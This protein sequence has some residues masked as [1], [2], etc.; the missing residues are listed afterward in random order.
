[1]RGAH[2]KIVDELTTWPDINTGPGRFAATAF[3]VGRRE[4]G[5]IHGDGVVD[6]P[7]RKEKCAEW[8][9]TGHAEQHRFAPNF[10]VSI[11]LRDADDVRGALELLRESYEFATRNKK[12]I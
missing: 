7:C 4:I 12:T 5:H 10:G 8:I 9:A 1:M 3:Y 11:F 2:K 6:I